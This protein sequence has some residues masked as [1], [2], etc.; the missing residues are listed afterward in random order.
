MSHEN[1]MKALYLIAHNRVSEVEANLDKIDE[2]TERTY[3]T[4][5]DKKFAA[6]GRWCLTQHRENL[7]D[8]DGSDIQDA[9]IGFGLLHEVRVEKPC[10]EECSCVEY[11]GSDNFPADCLREVYPIVEEEKV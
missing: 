10:A 7:G 9:A 5:A 1:Q 11:Y 4:E 8:I 6:F 2:L 3:V